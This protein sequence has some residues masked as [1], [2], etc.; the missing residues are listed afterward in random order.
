M[1]SLDLK[2]KQSCTFDIL[3]LGEIMLRLDPGFGKN[4]LHD[5]FLPL[6]G[7]SKDGCSRQ[8]QCESEMKTARWIVT[9]RGQTS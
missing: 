6:A 2:P 4:L 9:G 7:P 8:P 3:S 1:S 5:V